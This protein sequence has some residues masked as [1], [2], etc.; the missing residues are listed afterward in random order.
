MISQKEIAN[1]IP[2]LYPV[3]KLRAQKES[4]QTLLSYT[5]L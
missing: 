5:W 1:N 2:S 4:I 3:E